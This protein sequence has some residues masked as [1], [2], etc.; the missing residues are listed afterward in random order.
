MNKASSAAAFL[1]YC[2]AAFGLSTTTR[3]QELTVNGDFELGNTSSWVSFPSPNSTFAITNDANSGMFAGEL[4]NLASTS[5]AVI[6]QANLGVGLVNP[7]DAVTI[8]FAAKGTLGVGG[9]IFAEFF[10][11]LAGGG[12]SASEI[13]S[14][15]PLNVTGTWQ[16]FNFMTVAGPN[17]SG[18]ITLQ[19]AAVPGAIVG[20]TAEVLIDDVSVSLAAS[21]PQNYCGPAVANS[22]GAS[23]VMSA[24]GSFI[25]A[26]NDTTIACDSMPT[27]AFSFF[28]TSR[29]Q[30]FSMMPGGSSGNLCL[31]GAIGRFTGPGQIQNSGGTG[32]V[33]L[34]L[35]LTQQPTPTGLVSVVS[36]DTWNFQCWFRDASMG[37]ATSNFSDGIEISFL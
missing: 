6:K 28:I 29:T 1:L 14:G 24:T 31:A 2:S 37:T 32:R 35:N 7:G 21:G 10:S 34:A 4:V 17:V 25:V 26:N 22:T 30:G 3:A 18:G 27:N 5:A 9:V 11:E 8:S 36:G 16:T 13:L 15:G 23:A 19:F 12:V 33:Q 20:S